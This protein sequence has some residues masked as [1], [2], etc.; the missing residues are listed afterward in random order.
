MDYHTIKKKKKCEYILINYFFSTWHETGFINHPG[1][2]THF[3]CES[4]TG[5]LLKPPLY[6]AGSSKKQ[7]QT[8]ACL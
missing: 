2:G 7:F 4:S 5:F 8:R 3:Y 6:Q 1:L